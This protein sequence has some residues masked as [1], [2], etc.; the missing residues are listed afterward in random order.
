MGARER[1]SSE[2]LVDLDESQHNAPPTLVDELQMLDDVG[3]YERV[4]RALGPSTILQPADP[5]HDDDALTPAA[6]R[7]LHRLQ[8]QLFAQL[9]SSTSV[10]GAEELRKATKFLRDS[11]SVLPE[12]GSSVILVS[13]TST[14]PELARKI[15]QALDD[16]FIERHRAQYS[17]QALLSA[18]RAQLEL[19]KTSRDEAAAAYVEL[20]SKSGIAALETQVPHLETELSALENELFEAKV[21]REEIARM[22]AALTDR[23]AGIPTEIESQRPAV[24]IPNEDYETQLALKRQLLGQKQEMLV[25]ERPGE[26]RKRKELEF[27]NQITKLDAKLAVTPKAVLQG[28]EMQENLG[29]SAMEAR[30]VDLEVEDDALPVKLGL[31]ESRLATKR[32]SLSEIQKQLLSATML[33]KDLGAARDA[34]ESRYAHMVDRLAVLETLEK[35]EAEEGPNLRVLQAPTLEPE[36]IGPKRG[37]L[38]LAGLLGGLVAAVALVLLR[39]YLERRLRHPETFE[40]ACGVP[41]LALVPQLASMRRLKKL[42]RAGRR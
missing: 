12:P 20:V 3:I 27:D 17:L 11:T 41:V 28:A 30:I 29:H 38:V 34:E 10:D 42:A 4:A 33:R 19:G 39:Q 18:S 40:L 24:M 36:K 8:G 14:S 6:V 23:L 21:R 2:A 16:A 31:L 5:A 13:N 35:A 7:L 25:K 1:L 32:E 9:N 22:R 15:V 37:V 26:E